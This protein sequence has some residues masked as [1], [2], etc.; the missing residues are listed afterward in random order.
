MNFGLG[1]HMYNGK[2]GY[3]RG[4]GV[5]IYLLWWTFSWTW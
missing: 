2:R 5:Y 4:G 3:V 1:F